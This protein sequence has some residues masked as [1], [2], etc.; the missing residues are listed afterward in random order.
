MLACFET[1]ALPTTTDEMRRHLLNFVVVGGGPTGIEFSA[2]LHDFIAQ[3]LSRIYPE[4]INFCQITVYDIAPEVLSMFDS[5]LGKIAMKSL[6]REGIRIKTSHHVEELRRGVP[7]A[8]EHQEIKDDRTCWTLKTK[9][10]G[11]TGVGMVVWSTGLMRNPFVEKALNK[12]YPLLKDNVDYVKVDLSKA[13]EINWMIRKDR[14]TGSIITNDKLQ[15]ILEPQG[16]GQEEPRAILKDV[17]ALGD[18][19]MIEGTTFPATAQVASQKAEWLGK[20][21]NKDDIEQQGFK[22]KNMGVMAYIGSSNAIFQSGRGREVSGPLAWLI[23]RGAYL[24]KTVS[25]RN[26]ILVPIMWVLNSVFGRDIS[27]KYPGG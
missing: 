3:D 21:L 7:S 13:S 19:A 6:S 16:E 22:W 26:K 15:V 18:C 17:Y 20:R 24:T 4:L 11:D 14:K 27:R 2:E 23:W 25:W 10:E 8:G 9:E 5:R 1:A 12:I